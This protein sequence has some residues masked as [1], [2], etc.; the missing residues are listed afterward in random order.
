M[1]W[2]IFHHEQP[3]MPE[4]SHSKSAMYIISCNVLLIGTPEGRSENNLS[5]DGE[6]DQGDTANPSVPP[7]VSLTHE[8]LWKAYQRTQGQVS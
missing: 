8:W 3:P 2:L 6:T 5:S 7:H 1:Q 4:W